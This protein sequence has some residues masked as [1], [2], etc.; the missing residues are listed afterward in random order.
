MRKRSV[1]SVDYGNGVSIRTSSMAIPGRLGH[2][3]QVLLNSANE[4]CYPISAKKQYAQIRVQVRVLP[5]I[6]KF[7]EN[8]KL[9]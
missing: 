1:A 7:T 9:H 8:N 2:V 3:V 4:K 5:D 6:P